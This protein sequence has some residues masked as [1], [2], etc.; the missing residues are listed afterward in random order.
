MLPKPFLVI[1]FSCVFSSTCSL[2]SREHFTAH[3]QPQQNPPPDPCTTASRI[4]TSCIH[5]NPGFFSLATSE[6][7]RCLCY[8]N[9]VW[10]P[11][12]FD[13]A[14]HTCI[15]SFV[16]NSKYFLSIMENFCAR[17]GEPVTLVSS[18]SSSEIS[19]RSPATR[20]ESAREPTTSTISPS[21]LN[22]ILQAYTS[23]ISQLSSCDSLTDS[24]TPSPTSEIFTSTT[25]SQTAPQTTFESS[26]S[27]P[28]IHTSPTNTMRTSTSSSTNPFEANGT[29]GYRQPNVSYSEKKSAGWRCRGD[30]AS[31]LLCLGI[32]VWV[33][34]FWFGNVEIGI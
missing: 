28:P 4:L 12:S 14:V 27:I 20:T 15:T 21:L 25:A 13:N 5:A 19:T 33:L 10:T 8:H 29:P 6:Q 7:A 11:T 16:G 3:L 24:S 26:S 2:E 31:L 34:L 1:L 30:I 32:M 18:M 17:A 22:S 23:S 9:S